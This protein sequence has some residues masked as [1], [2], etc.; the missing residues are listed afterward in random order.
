MDGG[1]R[2]SFKHKIAQRTEAYD[3][4]FR[5]LWQVWEQIRGVV[6]LRC[7]IRL[8]CE[9]RPPASREY[10][11]EWDRR[12]GTTGTSN[13]AGHSSISPESCPADKQEYRGVPARR[14][15]NSSHRTLAEGCIEQQAL[16]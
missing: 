9:L 7:F 6:Q 1:N 2:G 15:S 10:L 4:Y 5:A 16:D 12:A 11:R 14:P 8:Q 13:R 3:Q